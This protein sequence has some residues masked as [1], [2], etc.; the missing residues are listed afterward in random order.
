MFY[1][2][3]RSFAAFGSSCAPTSSQVAGYLPVCAY[4]VST[5]L[6]LIANFPWML[7]FL[8]F[9]GRRSK[10]AEAQRVLERAAGE[11]VRLRREAKEPG[12]V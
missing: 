3:G 8:Q 5:F 2:V 7:R 10:V 9:I 6:F 12:K 4:Q 1:A 11:L